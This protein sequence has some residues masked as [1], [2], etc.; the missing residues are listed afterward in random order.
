MY[1]FERISF[2]TE[3]TGETLKQPTDPRAQKEA[4]RTR[5]FFLMLEIAGLFLIPALVAVWVGK[6]LD[7][8]YE[9]G[10]TGK[11]LAL[12]V[13]F[14]LSWVCVIVR[15]RQAVREGKR[16]DAEITQESQ[17]S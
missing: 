2:M 16:I 1:T 5:L 15:Y 10:N 4:F 9:F 17:S 13:A 11:A 12:L 6:W 3:T 14:V 7:S 8:S